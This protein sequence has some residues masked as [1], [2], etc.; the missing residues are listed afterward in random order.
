VS[1]F[2][3]SVFAALALAGC[4]VAPRAPESGASPDPGSL[5]QWTASGRIAIAAGTEGGSGSFTW[6]QD[7]AETRLDL[8]GPLGTGAVR[9]VVTP[10]SLSLADGAGQTLDA[11]AA[12]AELRSRL[13]ADLPWNQ[14]RYWM[15]GLADPG[16]VAIVQEADSTPWRVIEQSGWRLAYQSF[17]TVQGVNVPQRFSAERESVRVRVIVDAWSAPLP[18]GG[19]AEARP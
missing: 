12:R 19:A 17:A 7:D 16:E 14:L 13:G 5:R 9:L 15:L 11:E 4:A 2:P 1:R 8:R 18:S 6:I 3:W 10:G